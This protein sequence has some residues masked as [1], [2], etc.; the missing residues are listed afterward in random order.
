MT[1]LPYAHGAT[2]MTGP[3]LP[4]SGDTAV[5]LLHGAHG[6]TP[7]IQDQAARIAALGVAVLCADLWA[8][9]APQGP[10]VGAALAAL[11]GDAAEWAGRVQAADAALRAQSGA[12]RIIG[13]GYCFGGT[14]ILNHARLGADL[15]AAVAFHPGL[16]HPL[17]PWAP[18]PARV[19]LAIGAQDPLA[20][21]QALTALTEAM[22][23]AGRDWE[24]TLFSH[25]RHGFTEPD[26]PGR[27]PFAAYHAAS[28]RR[29]WALFCDLLAKD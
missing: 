28:A 19:A 4:G 15:A 10:Q 29:A 3:Y 6:I 16:E 8:G 26:A 17:G 27:P 12:K 11:T 5:L 24:L 7:F 23:E 2:Q 1:P 18:G 9:P 13:L 21:P 22:T 20:P 14:S 25:A